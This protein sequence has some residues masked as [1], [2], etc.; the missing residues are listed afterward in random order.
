MVIIN[1]ITFRAATTI[2]FTSIWRRNFAFLFLS[3]ALVGVHQTSSDA[4]IFLFCNKTSPIQSI[5]YLSG[6]LLYKS[7]LSCDDRNVA[8]SRNKWSFFLLA[9]QQ[10]TRHPLSLPRGRESRA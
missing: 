10:N 3:I 9:R 5:N 6:P 7:S 2:T 8:K 1:A 4:I